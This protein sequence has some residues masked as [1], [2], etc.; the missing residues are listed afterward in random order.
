MPISKPKISIGSSI[1]LD[2]TVN[3]VSPIA[4]LGCPEER[5]RLLKP[6]YRWVT[7]LPKRIMDIYSL[8]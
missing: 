2:I 8:A 4:V 6:K 1:A 7:T 3:S 5:M